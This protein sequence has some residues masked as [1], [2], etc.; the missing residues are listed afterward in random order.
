MTSSGG[1]VGSHDDGRG[2]ERKLSG[3]PVFKLTVFVAFQ[4]F[5]SVLDRELIFSICYAALITGLL[6]FFLNTS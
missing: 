1:D 3:F 5:L 2:F 4:K 6:C